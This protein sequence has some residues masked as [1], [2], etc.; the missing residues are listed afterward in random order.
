MP[1][2]RSTVDADTCTNEGDNVCL[3]G[4][5]CVKTTEQVAGTAQSSCTCPAGF[6]G[7]RCE[8]EGL[9]DLQCQ[10]GGSCRHN[11][12]VAHANSGTSFACECVGPYKGLEC[13][14][15]FATC[16][17]PIAGGDAQQV[18]CLWGGECV[19][20][21]EDEA[22]NYYTCECPVGRYGASCEKEAGINPRPD[23]DAIANV[24]GLCRDDGDCNN[25]GLCVLSHDV[26]NTAAM[27]VTTKRSQCL[28]TLGWGGDACEIP[29]RT[30]SC[31]HGSSCRFAA[32][33]VSHAN[34]A[35]EAGAYCACDAARFKGQECEIAVQKC[36]GLGGVECLYGG[37]CIPERPGE[38]AA[39]IYTCACPPGRMGAR[40]ET[41]DPEYRGGKRVSETLV[42][43][44][45]GVDPILFVIAAA[46]VALLVVLPVTVMIIKRS[47]KQK[48]KV[49]R[50]TTGGSQGNT[51]EGSEVVIAEDA[52][53]V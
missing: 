12:D 44:K 29:C 25:G 28:C 2:D 21:D 8:G 17:P 31:Q 14:V 23:Q 39:E 35:T 49:F 6:S 13:E 5:V 30:L 43:P 40:C 18:E 36:P 34:D 9:C 3:N 24:I 27:G 38:L 4:G 50:S 47:H 15:P 16:P 20:E 19:A 26:E 51:G 22:E 46:A 33:D 10:H 45:E 37:E 53:V 32:E 1:V 48:A 7:A 52:Q 42:V 11:E 41:L